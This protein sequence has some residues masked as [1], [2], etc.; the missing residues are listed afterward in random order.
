M[1]IPPTYEG[2]RNRRHLNQSQL[3]TGHLLT[4]TPTLLIAQGMS[5]LCPQRFPEGAT[6]LSLLRPLMTEGMNST[7]KGHTHV[8]CT[9]QLDGC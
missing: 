6:K 4:E 2:L 1:E 3:W 8:P 7:K 9:V 5:S